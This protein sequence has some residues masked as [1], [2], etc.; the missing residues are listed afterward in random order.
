MSRSKYHKQSEPSVKAVSLVPS[1]VEPSSEVEVLESL[2]TLK[3]LYFKLK[4]DEKWMTCFHPFA[5]SDDESKAAILTPDN[6]HGFARHIE[7]RKKGKCE[8]VPV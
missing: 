8:V 5:V 2:E 6:A 3:P 1:K 4:V 7:F